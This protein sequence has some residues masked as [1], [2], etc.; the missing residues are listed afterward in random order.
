MEFRELKTFQV[1]ASLLSFSNAANVLHMAQ[2]TVSA[3]IRSLEYSLGKDLFVRS[4]K[5]VSL[6]SAGVKLMD[7]TQVP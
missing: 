2:S 1:V 7:Y 6:T 4:G 5:K 3:Q